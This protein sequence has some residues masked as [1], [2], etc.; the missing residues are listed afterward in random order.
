MY[1]NAL[2]I[3]APLPLLTLGGHSVLEKDLANVQVASVIRR[4]IMNDMLA[5]YNPFL[6]DEYDLIYCYSGDLAQFR[7]RYKYTVRRYVRMLSSDDRQVGLL[8]VHG[9]TAQSYERVIVLGTDTPFITKSL[10]K[11]AFHRLESGDDIVLIPDQYG[12]YG[13]LGISGFYDLYSR[14][15]GW[16][17]QLSMFCSGVL[18]VANETDLNIFT[19]PESSAVYDKE[20]LLNVYN[21]IIRHGSLAPD[22]FYLQKTYSILQKHKDILGL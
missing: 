16:N 19:Y 7:S 5:E 6:E 21:Q 9:Y 1:K 18:Q 14:A 11:N 2:I 15:N 3:Y 8:H 4:A 22:Y 17:D 10:I 13:C 20:D 12:G